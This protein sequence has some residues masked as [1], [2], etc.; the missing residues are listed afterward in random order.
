MVTKRLEAYDYSVESGS[1]KESREAAV[2]K[3]RLFGKM[4]FFRRKSA[5]EAPRRDVGRQHVLTNPYH[6]VSVI[7]PTRS[8]D[9]ARTLEGRRF[10]SSEAPR[11]PLGNCTAATCTCKYAHHEDRRRGPRRSSDAT[12][13]SRGYWNAMERRRPGGRRIT[14]Q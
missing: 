1:T 9:A 13:L 6:A 2:T 11:L 8:C 14:D 3:I 5:D 7:S 4:R 10:L 12:G